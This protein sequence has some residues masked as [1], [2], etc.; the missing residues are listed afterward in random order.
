MSKSKIRPLLEL[1][2]ELVTIEGYAV[3]SKVGAY[4]VTDYGN[5]WLKQS[6]WRLEENNQ[7]VIVSGVLTQGVDPMSRIPVAKQDESGAWSQ[8][9]AP[10]DIYNDFQNDD[11]DNPSSSNAPKTE[12]AW[13]IKVSKVEIVPKQ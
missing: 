8:G 6:D 13:I 12:N 7:K 1:V 5:V 11:K 4:L 9:V 3:R 10:A 2:G